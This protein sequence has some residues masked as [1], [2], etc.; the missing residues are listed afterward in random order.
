MLRI[1]H[2]AMVGEILRR[3]AR[4]THAM[5]RPPLTGGLFVFAIDLRAR[6]KAC[7]ALLRFSSRSFLNGAAECSTTSLSCMAGLR[8]PE[9]TP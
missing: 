9:T 5:L 6:A 2:A 3:T 8:K 7:F 4:D 1:K